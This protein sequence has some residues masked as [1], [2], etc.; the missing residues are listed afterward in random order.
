MT[1]ISGLPHIG[2]PKRKAIN[3]SW[4]ISFCFVWSQ[5]TELY[6][7]YFVVSC[8][9]NTVHVQ[10][11]AQKQQQSSNFSVILRTWFDCRRVI[12]HRVDCYHMTGWC[13]DVM[14]WSVPMRKT[15]TEVWTWARFQ[16]MDGFAADTL[17]SYHWRRRLEMYVR[18]QLSAT[19]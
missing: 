5:S 9:R 8:S 14:S 4:K 12:C 11:L 18:Q 17:S 10:H 6:S 13:H 16:L 15:I 2:R 3:T 19:W 7:K 1:K